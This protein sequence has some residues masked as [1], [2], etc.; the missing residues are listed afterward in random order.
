MQDHGGGLGRI[1]GLAGSARGFEGIWAAYRVYA[2]NRAW[3]IGKLAGPCGLGGIQEDLAGSEEPA[4]S[5]IGLGVSAGLD[6]L[7]DPTKPLPYTPSTPS[8]PP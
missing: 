7:S 8:F 3:E 2:G 4:G 5:A 6:S 1:G